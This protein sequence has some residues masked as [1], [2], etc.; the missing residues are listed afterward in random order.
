MKTPRD[1]YL[2]AFFFPCMGSASLL[3]K[4]VRLKQWVREPALSHCFP[5]STTAP[6]CKVGVPAQSGGNEVDGGVG[7]YDVD[8]DGPNDVVASLDA[9][10]TMSAFLHNESTA[11]RTLQRVFVL[12]L[13]KSSRPAVGVWKSWRDFQGLW[14]RR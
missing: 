4:S 6:H 2:A 5:D 3:G 8:G 13:L 9:W 12:I 7:V 1:G 10:I 11:P 14:E